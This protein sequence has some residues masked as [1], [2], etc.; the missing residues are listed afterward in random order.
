MSIDLFCYAAQSPEA[1]N[2]VIAKLAAKHQG[3]FQSRFLISNAEATSEIENEIASEYGLAAR[4]IFLISLNDKNYADILPAVEDL[5]K[6]AFP[7]GQVVILFNNEI[8][9]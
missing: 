6:L 9:R 4:S 5:V 2:A 8:L 3:L 7:S 1:A